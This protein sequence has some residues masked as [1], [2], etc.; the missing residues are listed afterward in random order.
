MEKSMPVKSSIKKLYFSGNCLTDVYNFAEFGIQKIPKNI[1][2]N[3][4]VE[5]FGLTDEIKCTLGE[6]IERIL[7]ENDIVFFDNIKSK[8]IEKYFFDYFKEKFGNFELFWINK[9]MRKEYEK[10][11]TVCI[12]VNGEL[13]GILKLR[14][15]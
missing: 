15:I 12:M 11:S 8:G 5:K 6:K 2:K 1:E 14:K 4:E 13:K 3:I 7:E 10:N 9:L